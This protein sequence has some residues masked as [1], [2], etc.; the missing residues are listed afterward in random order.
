[1]STGTSW[2]PFKSDLLK[3]P[4]SGR[5]LKKRNAI[6]IQFG[7]EKGGLL[8][9]GIFRLCLFLLLHNCKFETRLK[10]VW[11]KNNRYSVNVNARNVII[12]SSLK[13][14]LQEHLEGFLNM[15]IIARFCLIASLLML[16]KIHIY[17]SVQST[18]A[19]SPSRPAL[20]VL[21]PLFSI[22]PHHASLLPSY[23]NLLK[24]HPI[25]WMANGANV[26]LASSRWVSWGC[27]I[28]FVH[29]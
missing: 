25:G 27:S 1:M 3:P 10:I 24:L 5:V 14:G 17:K 8:R 20:L 22:I 26:G 21:R 11:T 13:R 2:P 16:I 12:L 29:Y 28:L 18:P 19:R 7:F 9:A 15:V 23:H 4:S 6:I